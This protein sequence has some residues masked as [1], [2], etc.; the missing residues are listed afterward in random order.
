VICRGVDWAKS[1]IA[2]IDTYQA[3]V[4]HAHRIDHPLVAIAEQFEVRPERATEESDA[5]DRHGIAFQKVDVMPGCL[6]SERGDGPGVRLSIKLVIAADINDRQ[7][8]EGL[9]HH[10][11]ASRA[12]IDV[13]G[14]HDN[15]GLGGHRQVAAEFEVEVA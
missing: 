2:R 7:I 8:R 15:I 10:G 14:K 13:A 1:S 12:A 3:E 4:V 6:L 11:D 5:A 9:S